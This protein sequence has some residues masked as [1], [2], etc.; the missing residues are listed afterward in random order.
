MFFNANG[1]RHR[2]DVILKL[3]NQK[4]LDLV[5]VVESHLKD[6]SSLLYLLPAFSGDSGGLIGGIAVFI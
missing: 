3:K 2:Y 5:F 6:Q 4:L 1:N